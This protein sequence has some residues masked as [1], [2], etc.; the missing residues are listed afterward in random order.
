MLVNYFLWN[1]FLS[2][3]FKTMELGEVF[4]GPKYLAG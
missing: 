4:Y 2:C 3:Y 1:V